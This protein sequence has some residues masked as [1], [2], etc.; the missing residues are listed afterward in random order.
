MEKRKDRGN[1]VSVSGCVLP[2]PISFK[3]AP[4]ET[5]DKLELLDTV[6]A[7]VS[8]S[9]SISRYSTWKSSDSLYSMKAIDLGPLCDLRVSE[10][11]AP[12]DM[13]VYGS[14]RSPSRIPKNLKSPK[15]RY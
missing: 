12:S 2:R 9:K 15:V 8:L 11:S 3:I 1:E 13:E 10:K 14:P 6:T 5:I 7:P 4:V